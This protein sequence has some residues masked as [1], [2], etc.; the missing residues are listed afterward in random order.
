MK[1]RRKRDGGA[2]AR[3]AW[4]IALV[5]AAS[6][7][8]TGKQR[9]IR[10]FVFGFVRGKVDKL[11]P[12]VMRGFSGKRR[13]CILRFIHLFSWFLDEARSPTPCF[14]CVPTQPSLSSVT[15]LVGAVLRCVQNRKISSTERREKPQKASRP[16]LVVCHT[17]SVR[18]VACLLRPFHHSPP[19]LF[20]CCLKKPFALFALLNILCRRRRR[21]ETRRGGGRGERGGH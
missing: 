5:L 8:L 18:T 6:A 20:P 12:F 16:G 9:F 17:L 3:E 1:R 19:S 14:W 11:L 4:G 10:D 15:E 7:A 13:L 2:S 21:N